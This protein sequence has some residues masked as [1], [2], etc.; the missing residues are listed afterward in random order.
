MRQDTEMHKRKREREPE[1]KKQAIALAS[2]RERKKRSERISIDLVYECMCAPAQQREIKH[3]RV[4]K[5]T[6]TMFL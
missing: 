1:R 4:T 5:T 2:S 6:E 3:R